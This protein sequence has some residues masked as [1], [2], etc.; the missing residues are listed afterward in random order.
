MTTCHI[1]G[2]RMCLLRVAPITHFAG[3]II[4][5]GGGPVKHEA[6]LIV[7]VAF[8]ELEGFRLVNK[9]LSVDINEKAGLELPCC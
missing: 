8:A 9:V 3:T 1:Y 2:P 4:S 6:E 5:G 7:E